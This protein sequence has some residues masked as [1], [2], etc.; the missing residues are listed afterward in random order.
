M[1]VFDKELSD[2]ISETH[3]KL[4]AHCSECTFVSEIDWKA[5]MTPLSG[6][7]HVGDVNLINQNGGR[8]SLHQKRR[9]N[10]FSLS[11]DSN[12]AERVQKKILEAEAVL[13]AFLHPQSSQLTTQSQVTS[14]NPSI[15]GAGSL[16]QGQAVD[17]TPVEN[18]LSAARRTPGQSK[19][20]SFSDRGAAGRASRANSQGPE[21]GI[22][23]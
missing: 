4:N 2:A 22:K 1:T 14:E 7:C 3:R 8:G 5:G 13:E 23:Q 12:Q 21:N 19:S 20:S 15:R 18:R 17:K 11:S 6:H 10:G 9:C 16:E